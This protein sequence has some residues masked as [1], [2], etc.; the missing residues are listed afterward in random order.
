[1][2]KYR[3]P[4]LKEKA[5]SINL[6]AKIYGSFSEIGAGQEVAANFFQAGG[7]SGTI[8]HSTSAYDMKIS[9]SLY[10]ETRRYVC[11]ERLVTMLD[12]EFKHLV[13]KLPHRAEES[14]F[15]S[16][17]DT[18][19]TINY[20]KS[21][22]GHGWMG[23]KFQL[24][25]QGSVNE[26]V[27]HVKMHDNVAL[28]QQ[29]ALGRLG[30]NLIYAAFH[31][32]QNPEKFLASLVDGIDSGRLE[33]DM[34]R[35]EGPDFEYIDNRLM[36]LQLVRMG[37][38]EA[39][40]FEPDGN[41]QQPTDVLYKKNV[42]V[43]RGRFRP[44]TLVNLDM[45]NK[46][47]EL[48]KAD[49]EVNP[50]NILCLFELTLKDL[51][52]GGNI[53][54]KD[55]LDRIDTLRTLG[56]RVLI[57]NYVK[58]Y[59]LVQYIS[60]VT[61]GC[62]VGVVLGYKNMETIFDESFYTNLPGGLLEAFGT[63]FGG[64][65]KLMVYPQINHINGQMEVGTKMRVPAHLEGLLTY[66]LDNNKIVDIEN[67]DGEVLHIFSDDVLHMIKTGK[68]GWEVMVPASVAQS[69]K[70]KQLFNY[71]VGEVSV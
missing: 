9:D 46:G 11:Q 32:Y 30:V 66:F 15:F 24:R 58:Y 71:P 70:E 55:F 54:P 33:I 50:D 23:I 14:K 64:K 62:K 53:D 63:G 22:Q 60:Q 57:S 56:H 21:N 43:Q 4:T 13:E 29:R 48:F 16:F 69:I 42:F 39:T 17:A 28:L 35:F 7:A 68:K 59:K 3:T 37:F 34:L 8:A 44:V 31:Y 65:V 12:I 61:K 47:L 41:V 25:P 36:A 67:A 5:L 2:D 51:K 26:V 40:I 49:P 6:D 10:G 18:V 45:F 1:M 38:T 27:L 52:A 20:H 19:E